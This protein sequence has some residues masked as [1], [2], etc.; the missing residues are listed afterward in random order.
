MATIKGDNNPNGLTGTSAGGV[1]RRFGR[2]DTLSGLA[3]KDVLLGGLGDDALLGGVGNDRLDGG[4]GNDRLDGG[5]G[6]HTIA[7]GAGN[8]IY[9]VNSA[10]D[11]TTER[12]GSGTDLVLSAISFTPAA[13]AATSSTEAPAPTPSTAAL[14]STSRSMATTCPMSRDPGA[15]SMRREARLHARAVGRL[16]AAM[17]LRKIKIHGD[18]PRCALCVVRA[19]CY[20]STNR[21]TGE[22]PTP[23]RPNCRLKRVG[24]Q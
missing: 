10:G 1:I 6:N 15:A 8:D 9:I 2:N 18:S 24:E 5:T 16:A 7:G 11:R 13:T 19:S 21:R 14:A 12:P 23:E 20:A 17:P 22:T 3:G 4:A